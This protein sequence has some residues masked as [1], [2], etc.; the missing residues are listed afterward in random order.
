LSIFLIHLFGDISSP[1]LIGFISDLFGKQSVAGSFV[2]R[3]LAQIG[4]VPVDAKNLTAGMLSVVPILAV[5]C[6][7]F[8]LGSRHL[9]ED[10]DRARK[11]GGDDPLGEVLGH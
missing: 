5:G 10:Q 3:F 11:A 6:V 2:G 4:A 7:F 1:I 8:L 9:A